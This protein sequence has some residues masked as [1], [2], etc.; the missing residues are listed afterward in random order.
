M[1]S[2]TATTRKYGS[3]LIMSFSAGFSNA[4]CLSPDAFSLF[5]L[6]QFF[7]E[8]ALVQFSDEARIH[9][10]FRLA[11]AYFRPR[12]RNVVVGGFQPLHDWIRDRD[13][14]VLVDFVGPFQQF[15]IVSLEI[16]A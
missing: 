8:P 15:T 3:N 9:K 2:N 12:C 11:A 16:L 14:I 4:C 10:F 1:K 7:D 5:L 6:V 13:K